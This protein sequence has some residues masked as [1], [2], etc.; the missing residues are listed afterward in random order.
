MKKAGFILFC[1]LTLSCNTL[2]T[3]TNAADTG[4]A[5]A[6]AAVAQAKKPTDVDNPPTEE[7]SPALSG[8]QAAVPD[9]GVSSAAASEVQQEDDTAGIV[10]RAEE[11]LA[12]IDSPIEGELPEPQYP[13]EPPP[14]TAAAPPVE[15]PEP[16]A[17]ETSAAELNEQAPQAVQ[18]PEPPPVAP[19]PPPLMS[20]PPVA[21][22]QP[23]AP[24]PV[25]PP[26]APSPP[27][28][29]T[30]PPVEAQQAAEV[31]ETAETSPETEAYKH[32]P[33]TLDSR[34]AARVPSETVDRLEKPVPSRTVRVRAGQLLEVPFRGTGWV[35]MG[36]ASL[37]HDGI[38]FDSRKQD[39]DGMLFVFNPRK[40]GE[41][42]LRFSKHDFYN[43]YQIEDS[44]AVIVGEPELPHPGTGSFDAVAEN[45][46]VRASPRWPPIGWSPQQGVGVGSQETEQES[47][48][49]GMLSAGSD[50][51][52]KKPETGNQ[53]LAAVTK[54]EIGNQQPVTATTAE[55]GSVTQ[56][57]NAAKSAYD[58]GNIALALENL[59]KLDAAG[60][61]ADDTALYLRGK[62]Y[63]APGSSRNIKNSVSAY[64]ALIN[65]FPQSPYYNEAEKRI[66]Y[67]KK[68]YFNIR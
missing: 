18:T 27:L 6:E 38:Q 25:A 61:E 37:K 59:N 31:E 47:M 55:T 48:S 22:S 3:K 68:Y 51:P 8:A 23:V 16:A 43:D 45:A 54:P 2:P 1:A 13:E 50:M 40:T 66:A 46:R 4:K 64:T 7:K 30:Q 39:P 24:Q 11:T 19:N 58:A 60:I 21:A 41:Y 10:R 36:E 62:S 35:Y 5:A 53:Q 63:E 9:G 34:P 67:L 12:Y 17:A 28:V 56:L 57:V 65:Q 44:V 15:T 29:V 42:T 32:R 26:A 49:D 33:K 52:D 20:N 14:Q